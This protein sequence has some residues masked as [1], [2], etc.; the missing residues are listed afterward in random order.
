[1]RDFLIQKAYAQA[2]NNPSGTNSSVTFDKLYANI[3]DQI[4][5]PII[6]LLFALAVVYFVWGVLV[7]IRN[8]DNPEERKTGYQHMIWGV[9]GIFVMV[10]AIGIINIITAT[11]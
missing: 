9:I 5:T 3:K 10:S 4:V 6:Y 7:F 8:A 1:M 2:I 11:L